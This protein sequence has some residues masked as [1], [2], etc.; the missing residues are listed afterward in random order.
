[1]T[2]NQEKD[3]GVLM[4]RDMKFS[5]HISNIVRKANQMLGLI[6]SSFDYMCPESFLILYKSYVRPH[7]EYAVQAW[8]PFLRKDIEALERVQRRATKLVPEIRNLSYENRLQRLNL[9]TLEERRKRGDLIE[10]YKIITG[11]EDVASS[12]FFEENKNRLR[13]ND[14]KIF[15]K[16]S[17]KNIRKYFFSQRVVDSWNRLRNGIVN[18]TTLNQFKKRYDD[19]KNHD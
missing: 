8:S 13:G 15:K 18:A 17:R 19:Y 6:K 7:M 4:T 10:T 11:L 1:M 2:V 3:L 16:Q 12:Q 5:G 9:T 14:N